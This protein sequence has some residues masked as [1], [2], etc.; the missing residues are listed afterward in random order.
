MTLTEELLTPIDP[1]KIRQ[2]P[3]AHGMTISYIEGYV[4]IDEL[5]SVFGHLGWET[6]V[7]DMQHL[8]LENVTRGRGDL[9]YRRVPR[10]RALDR[11][12]S[13]HGH[14]RGLRVCPRGG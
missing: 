2:R 1:A 6:E 13:G 11:P 7:R 8:R 9:L 4:V 14:P 10:R 3:G 5:N 12:R